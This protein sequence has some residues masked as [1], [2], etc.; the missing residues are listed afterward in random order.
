[1]SAQDPLSPCIRVCALDPETGLCG[2]C[3][4]TLA[5]IAGWSGFSAEEK[6][7]ILRELEARKAAYRQRHRG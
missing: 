4:R 3:Y 1:M 6:C 5:E 7:A 2:G